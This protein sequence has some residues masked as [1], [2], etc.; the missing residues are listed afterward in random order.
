MLR[1]LMC[2]VGISKFHVASVK[3]TFRF[4]LYINQQTPSVPQT[5]SRVSYLQTESRKRDNE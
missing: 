4:I 3:Q 1:I 2:K 5:L